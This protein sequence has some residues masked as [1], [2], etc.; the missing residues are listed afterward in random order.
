MQEIKK[1]C[2]IVDD[3]DFARET[4]ADLLSRYAELKI[5]KSLSN[6]QTAIKHIAILKPDIVFL[7]FN[8]PVKN[9]M[10]VLNEIK[11]L[12]IKSKIVFVT[13]FDEFLIE[14]LK[15]G[16]FDYLIKPIN[17]EELNECIHR[18]L[19]YKDSESENIQLNDSISKNNKISIKNSHGSFFFYPNELAYIE[20]DGCYSI[21]HLRNNKTEVISKNLG[22]IETLFPK[23]EFYKISRSIIVNLKY[24]NKLDRLK[25]EIQLYYNGTNIKLKVSK[26][27][28]NKLEELF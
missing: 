6:S 25:K 24:L 1:T 4:L 20:A 19:N 22:A 13:A 26:S 23:E 7:D 10:T 11:E 2:I 28:L 8:M 21:L 12:N 14:A 15:K 16:V 17:I 3:N 9:G 5:V 27:N 18:F